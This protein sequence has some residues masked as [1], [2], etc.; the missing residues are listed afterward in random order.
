MIITDLR[1]RLSIEILPAYF[2]KGGDWFLRDSAIK[3]LSGLIDEEYADFN[4]QVFEGA[5]DM[6]DAIAALNTV[7]VFADKKMVIVKSMLKLADTDKSLLETYLKNP[8][9]FA[10]FVAVDDTEDKIGGLFKYGDVVDCNQV[11]E[12]QLTEWAMADAKRNNATID[13]SAVRLLAQFTGCNMTRTMTEL[14]KLYAYCEGKP[15][16]ADMVNLLV[17]PD[18]DYKTY[19]LTNA[20]TEGNNAEA[21]K[22]L[23]SLL[24]KGE[25]PSGLLSMLTNQYRRMLEARISTLE[26]AELAKTLGVKL[27]AI[28]IAKGLASKYSPVQLKS[29]VDT[30]HSAEYSFKSG[31]KDEL[32]VL[33]EAFGILL[34]K[35]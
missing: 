32:A 31:G 14:K 34:K 26:P 28:M 15:I 25:S 4:L 30:L 1:K 27:N 11:N 8:S 21:L 3:I 23:Q 13:A 6:K 16:T 12:M 24:E 7:P 33:H 19:K 18:N 5:E 29:I 35:Q 22:I 10:V 9:E 17:S 20:I 2:L